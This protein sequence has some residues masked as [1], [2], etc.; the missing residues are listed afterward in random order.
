MKIILITGTAG[1][2]SSKVSD[3]SPFRFIK[4]IMEDSALEVFGYGNQ[5][6]HFTYVDDIAKGKIKA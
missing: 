2:I 1:F 3:M 5:Q 4:W 6:R